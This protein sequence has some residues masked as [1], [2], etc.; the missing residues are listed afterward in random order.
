M[1]LDGLGSIDFDFNFGSAFEGMGV[2]DSVLDTNFDETFEAGVFD[3]IGKGI[4]AETDGFFD[5]KDLDETLQGS[6]EKNDVFSSLS[7][8]DQA[9][10]R[11]NLATQ[12][13]EQAGAEEGIVTDGTDIQLKAYDNA[14]SDLQEKFTEGTDSIKI[15]DLDADLQSQAKQLG[16][17]EDGVISK[18][19]FEEL[20]EKYDGLKDNDE[21][22][23]V[24]EGKQSELEENELLA[25]DTNGD[26]EINDRDGNFNT[27]GEEAKV[28]DEDDKT[29]DLRSEEAK[30]NG[31]TSAKAETDKSSPTFQ[32][33]MKALQEV[34]K[35][36]QK[37]AQQKKQ[38]QA[39]QPPPQPNYNANETY[40]KNQVVMAGNSERK[41][42]MTAHAANT[43]NV[44]ANFAQR[45]NNA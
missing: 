35:V 22:T 11:E 37:Q 40:W 14:L 23:F 15:E 1:S 45:F 17:D 20:K 25:L 12:F 41:A 42:W 27:S 31:D 5:N 8:D 36:M 34:M 26:G 29:L 30:K 3:D 21:L 9:K 24:T 38:S 13:W 2:E 28:I 39:Q 32:K 33:I 43:A 18:A 10:V 6:L 7:K 44:R 19:S 16:I 4:E